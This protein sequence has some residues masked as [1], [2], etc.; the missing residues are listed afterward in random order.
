[1]KAFLF[2]DTWTDGWRLLAI[3]SELLSGEQGM[4]GAL[5]D[6]GDDKKIMGS[7][8]IQRSPSI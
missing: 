7:S 4:G 8:V 6:G 2:L 3:V 5:E 1:M